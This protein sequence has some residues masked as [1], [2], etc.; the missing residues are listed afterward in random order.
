MYCKKCKD[1]LEDEDVNFK[2]CCICRFK[3]KM[4]QRK[5]RSFATNIN[6]DG[7]NFNEI[8]EHMIKLHTKILDKIAS[9]RSY[10]KKN[11]M[12]D[13]TEFI[14][15]EDIFMKLC[16][17]KGKCY[18]CSQNLKILNYRRY[19]S[20][21][22]SIDRLDSSIGHCKQNTVISCLHCNIKKGSKTQTEYKKT[23]SLEIE[24][25]LTL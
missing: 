25:V 22:M 3:N 17:H 11:N 13:E 8:S 9:H 23:L 12:Y 4:S 5:R 6:N 1:H 15:F 21:Q 20:N 24:N 2:K 16:R 18:Y 10:D 19:Q 14:N 7:L